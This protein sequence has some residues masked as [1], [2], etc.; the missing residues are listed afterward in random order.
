MQYSAGGKPFLFQTLDS[1]AES[2]F[3][4][5]AQD[6]PLFLAFSSV[7]FRASAS[8]T[9]SFDMSAYF[10]TMS[11]PIAERPVSSAANKVLPVPTKGSTTS[12]PFLVKKETKSLTRDSGNEAGCLIFRSPLGSGRWTNHDFVNLIH[13]LP[14]RSLSLFLG[15][16]C[17]VVS[18]RTS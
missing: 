10:L 3:M 7:P 5:L 1:L 17:L 2:A 15:N 9:R 8:L 12:S 14:E 11:N 13:S 16:S 18:S 6:G 4:I